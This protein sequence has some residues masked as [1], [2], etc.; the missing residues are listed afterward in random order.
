[1]IEVVLAYV[2]WVGLLSLGTWGL[3][4]WD[5][6]QAAL[7]GRRIPE[8]TLLTLSALGGWPG[9]LAGSWLFRHKTKKESFLVL[10]YLTILLHG[11][12]AVLVLVVLLRFNGWV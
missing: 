2:A 7:G 8:S 1:M 10:L 3:F 11:S 6:R 4:G 12:V 5:K 9:A